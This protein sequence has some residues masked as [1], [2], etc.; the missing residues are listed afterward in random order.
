[1]VSDL[2]VAANFDRKQV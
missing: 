1:M 2:H